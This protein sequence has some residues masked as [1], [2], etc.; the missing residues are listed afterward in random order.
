MKANDATVR[1]G[2]A[3]YRI[4]GVVYRLFGPPRQVEGSTPLSLQTYFFDGDEQLQHHLLLHPP[5]PENLFHETEILRSLQ[6]IMMNAPN[7]YLQS[8]LG[9]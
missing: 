3:S 6:N 7:V 9:I 8:F 5:S 4:S 2:I 1:G